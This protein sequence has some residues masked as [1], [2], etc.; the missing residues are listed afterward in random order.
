MCLGGDLAFLCVCAFFLEKKKKAICLNFFL[1]SLPL[2]L[3]LEK[4]NY[5]KYNKYLLNW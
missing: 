2:R 1:H 5:K 4:L 3:T